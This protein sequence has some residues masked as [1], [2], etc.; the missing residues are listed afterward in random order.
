MAKGK[1]KIRIG[2]SGWYYNHWR[3]RFYPEELNKNAWFPFYTEN[4]NTVEIN[5]TFYQLPKEASLARW[6][7]LAP[8]DF[9]FSVKANRYITHIKRLKNVSSELARFEQAVGILGKKLGPVLYQLPPSMKKDLGL[10]RSFLEL[11]AKRQL[12]V[13]EFRHESW[14]ANDCYELLG[15]FGKSFCIQDM[16]RAAS[17]RVITGKLIYVRFHGAAARYAS[18]Y[19]RS[20]MASWAKWIKEHTGQVE[21]VWVYFNNDAEANAIINAKELKAKL[22]DG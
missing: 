22:A 12:A 4:F 3:G 20:Q 21:S 14:F 1:C 5:N 10:L 6:H 13:F 16:S 7:K 18:R 19:S 2:A 17:P 11:L 15:Q 8:A 9:V